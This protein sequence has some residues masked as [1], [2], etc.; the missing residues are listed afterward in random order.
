MII[1][2]N[3]EIIT[4]KY[5]KNKQRKVLGPNVGVKCVTIDFLS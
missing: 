2:K 5:K 1:L 4:I 3:N